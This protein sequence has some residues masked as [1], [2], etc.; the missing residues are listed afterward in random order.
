MLLFVVAALKFSLFL[1]FVAALK[2]KIGGGGAI[3]RGLAST[4]KVALP[5]PFRYPP[6]LPERREDGRKR[7]EEEEEKEEEE[8][9]EKEDK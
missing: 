6:P 3:K 9:E 5:N 1:F 7:G 8:E 4:P 2:L